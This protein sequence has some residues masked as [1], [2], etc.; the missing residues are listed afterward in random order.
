[1]EAKFNIG[2]IV[3][4][5]MGRES[6]KYMII[7]EVGDRQVYLADGDKRKFDRPK[8]KNTRHIRSTGF[9]AKEIVDSIADSGRVSNAKLRYVLQE[10][11]KNHVSRIEEKGE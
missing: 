4:V 10:F 9:I 1:M 2:E 11:M 8:K 7:I 5:L 3:E 6:G